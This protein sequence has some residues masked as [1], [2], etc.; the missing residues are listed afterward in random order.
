MFKRNINHHDG[1]RMVDGAKFSVK[2]DM[3]IAYVSFSF[4]TLA[5]GNIMRTVAL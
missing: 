1:M 3:T 5:R 4:N 2:L